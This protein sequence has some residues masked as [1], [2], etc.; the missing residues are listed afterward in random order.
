MHEIM[1]SKYI[2]KQPP[3]ATQS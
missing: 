1:R 2:S 3:C